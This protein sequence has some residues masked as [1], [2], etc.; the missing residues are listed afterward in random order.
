M[1]TQQL[2][3][4]GTAL[5][6]KIRVFFLWALPT[7]RNTSKQ[8]VRWGWGWGWYL[9]IG[10][11][12]TTIIQ[13]VTSDTYGLYAP[14]ITTLGIPVILIIYYKIRNKWIRNEKYGDKPW[15][16][17]FVAG[18]IAYVLTTLLIGGGIV[19]AN[20]MSERHKAKL[21]ERHETMKLI[22][23]IQ[24]EVSRFRDLPLEAL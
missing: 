9:L 14:L 7:L 15:M 20:V 16:A 13:R 22:T 24:K 10:V 12:G 23:E 17:S 11:Y 4:V 8:K 21:S 5:R 2:C 6:I 18:F 3:K 1:T 19:I